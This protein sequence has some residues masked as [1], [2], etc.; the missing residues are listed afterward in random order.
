MFGRNIFRRGIPGLKRNGRVIAYI[1]I[2]AGATLILIW[3][4][5][6]IWFVLA[7]TILVLLGID[8]YKK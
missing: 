2:G 7:G 5:I 3:L 4:P 1:S 6:W 8:I